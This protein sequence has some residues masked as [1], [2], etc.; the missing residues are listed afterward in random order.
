MIKV[1]VGNNLTRK[2]VTIDPEMTIRQLL[3]EQ[4]I[5]GGVLTLDGCYLEHSDLDRSFSDYGVV[6]SAVLLSI[7][8][9][10][11]A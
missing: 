6:E 4:G 11:N 10:D 5:N 2:T 3:D 7:V 8:K 9:A 1:T